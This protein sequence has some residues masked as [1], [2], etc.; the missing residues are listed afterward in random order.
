MKHKI[1]RAD[2]ALTMA[3]ALCLAVTGFLAGSA[4]RRSETALAAENSPRVYVTAGS[5]EARQVLDDAGTV[6]DLYLIA[7]E[8]GGSYAFLDGYGAGGIPGDPDGWK[9]VAQD[10][11]AMAVDK[12]VPAASDIPFGQWA[13]Q[14]DAGEPLQAGLYLLVAHGSEEG[15]LKSFE[16]EDGN[17]Y[18]ASEFR[19]GSYTVKVSPEIIALPAKEPDENGS[20]NTAGAGNWTWDVEVALK[21]EY[22]TGTGSI[23]IVKDLLSYETN[24]EAFFLFQAEGMLDGKNVYSNLVSIRFDNYGEKRVL[25]DN[26]PVGAEVT[27]TEIYST[28]GYSIVGVDSGAITVS[29]D[30]V[31]SVRFENEYDGNRDHGGGIMNN[32]DYDLE[33]GEWS[34]TQG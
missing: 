24:H 3:L 31:L 17:P 6:S 18:L 2:K 15:Y 7:T 16:D 1:K 27:V 20:I 8:S 29:A 22:E 21:P 28:P 32:F 23:E 33:R 19:S 30:E 25:L 10:A 4:G 9:A 34:W 13:G 26:I 11:A 14:D 12:R 5:E